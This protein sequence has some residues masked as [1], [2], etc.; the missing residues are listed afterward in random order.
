MALNILAYTIFVNPEL[1]EKTRYFLKLTKEDA[2]IVLAPLVSVLGDLDGDH[3]T[4]RHA[5]L[6]DFLRDEARSQKYYSNRLNT[7]LSILWF[8]NLASGRYANFV[9][10]K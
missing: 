4:F 9:Y 3:L 2:K 1:H 8:D 7:Y 10:C 6:P 5:S